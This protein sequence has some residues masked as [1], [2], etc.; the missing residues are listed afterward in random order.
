MNMEKPEP[1]DIGGASLERIKELSMKKINSAPRKGHRSLKITLLAAA[2]AAALGI[3]AFAV[4]DTWGVRDTSGL[5]RLEINRILREDN[6]VTAAQLVDPEG[7]VSYIRDGKVLFTLSAEEAA[8]Y[9]E[10]MRQERQQKVREST[11]KLDVDSMELF[12]NALTEIA[13]DEN[14]CFGDFILHNGNTVLLCGSDGG[15]FEL[16]A[17]DRVSISVVSGNECHARFGL[18]RDGV[19]AEEVSLHAAELAHTFTI[20]ADGEYCFTLAYYSAGADNFTD[21]KIVIE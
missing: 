9:D 4:A 17:G 10:A 14:G 1:M 13:V 19:M 2:I 12:P 6:H 16:K 11:D 20:P 18:V 7:N 8:A 15:V 5:S 3:T 21:G